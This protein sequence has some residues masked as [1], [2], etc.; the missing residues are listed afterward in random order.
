MYM[1]REKVTSHSWT[2]LGRNVK[3]A[4]YLSEGLSGSTE[5]VKE[6]GMSERKKSKNK[7][8]TRTTKE[9]LRTVA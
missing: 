1:N 5:P 9:H 8:K 4:A 3:Q 6:E 2:G 7:V